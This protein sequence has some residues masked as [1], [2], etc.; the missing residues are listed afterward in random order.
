MLTLYQNYR[1]APRIRRVRLRSRLAVGHPRSDRAPERL[2]EPLVT[3]EL[4]SH[5]GGPPRHSS[6]RFGQAAGGLDRTRPQ[7]PGLTR[8]LARD[9]QVAG[10]VRAPRRRGSRATPRCPPAMVEMSLAVMAVPH[11]VPMTVSISRICTLAP[12]SGVATRPDGNSV[13]RDGDGTSEVV[14]RGRVGPLQLDDQVPARHRPGEQVDAISGRRPDHDSGAR[15]SDV[16]EPAPPKKFESPSARQ[17]GTTP[18]PS[19]GRRR[20]GP[21]RSV[22]QRTDNDRVTRD[23]DREAEVIP[24]DRVGSLQLSDLAS[25]RGLFGEHI[26]SSLRVFLVDACRDGLT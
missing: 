8:L 13:A 19:P 9:V 10:A 21:L 14:V 7:L 2:P 24:S 17:P 25:A 22:S 5:V 23:G 12:Q 1:S 18:Q 6:P 26:C 20:R 3:K 4:L 11:W 15:N 16:A